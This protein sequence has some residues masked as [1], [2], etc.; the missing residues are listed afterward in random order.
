M[1]V[2][3][4]IMYQM[5]NYELCHLVMDELREKL[6]ELYKNEYFKLYEKAFLEYDYNLL[7]KESNKSY[8]QA[9][10]NYFLVLPL[11]HSQRKLIK[12]SI[13]GPESLFHL[14]TLRTLL[15]L[16]EEGHFFKDVYYT[17]FPDY[18]GVAYDEVVY[19]S[20]IEYT[21]DELIHGDFD[22]IDILRAGYSEFPEIDNFNFYLER[23]LIFLYHPLDVFIRANLLII[24]WI[25]AAYMNA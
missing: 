4:M 24:I 10:Y 14:P 18:P 6:K 13:L 12:G 9:C 7:E 1:P 16:G 19:V 5:T 23:V 3:K 17:L 8:E 11:D 22:L 15:F 21:T 20:L 25:I 2:E